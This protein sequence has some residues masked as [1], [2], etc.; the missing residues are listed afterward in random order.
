MLDKSHTIVSDY[1]P[2]EGPNDERQVMARPILNL[3]RALR[4]AAG[5]GQAVVVSTLLA[6]AKEQGVDTSD[7]ITSWIVN[8]T[9]IS[10]H[11][12]VFKALASA[13]PTVINFRLGHGRLP[14]YEA[15][16]LRQPDVVAALLE[17][18][19][20]PLHP[21]EP[22]KKLYG[23]HSSLLS[24]A[25]FSKGPRM[26]EMLLDHGVPIAHTAALHTAARY[27]Y[28]DTM[29]LLMDRGADVNEVMPN[30][31]NWTPMHFAASKGSVDAMKLLE[32]NGARSDLKDEDGKTPA[33]MLEEQ[34]A[35]AE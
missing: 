31:A 1:R 25:A 12:D 7:I 23:Y 20:D 21:V 6:F 18:G 22:S 27:G 4:A 30:W 14:F 32:Q 28:L 16:R 33:Q 34:N 8:K 24:H 9:I 17:L 13:D 10:G 5:N 11:G 2:T 19:A 35:A 26:T 3:E 29:R 15:V